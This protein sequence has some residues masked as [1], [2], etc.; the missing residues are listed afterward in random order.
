PHESFNPLMGLN[1]AM[2]DM[3]LNFVMATMF[4]VLPAFWIAALAWAGV[5]AGNALRGLN[6]ATVDAKNAGKSGS[7]IAMK[8]LK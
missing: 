3:L 1:N 5:S 8:T 2:G 7:G 4:F 6:D